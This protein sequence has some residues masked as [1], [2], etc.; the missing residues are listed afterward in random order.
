MRQY[1]SLHQHP[2]PARRN[3]TTFDPVGLDNE[4]RTVS[5]HGRP[6]RQR[7]LTSLFL[8][9]TTPRS[10]LMDGP[11]LIRVRHLYSRM[12]LIVSRTTPAH[13]TSAWKSPGT[14]HPTCLPYTSYPVC[15][16]LPEEGARRALLI[17]GRMSVLG[18]STFTLPSGIHAPGVPT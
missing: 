8:Y 2:T 10:N 1:Q 3:R 12:W 6:P 4:H 11:C 13:R 18:F 9:A 14:W 15:W 7:H 5:E 16:Y 17:D